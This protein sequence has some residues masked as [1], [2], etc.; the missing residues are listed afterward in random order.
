MFNALNNPKLADRSG[1]D[2]GFLRLG[3]DTGF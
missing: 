3:G 1:G 2:T